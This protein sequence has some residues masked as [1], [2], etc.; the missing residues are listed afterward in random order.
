M[1]GWNSLS[2]WRRYCYGD[3]EPRSV[4]LA[5]PRYLPFPSAIPQV[6]GEPIL[7]SVTVLP[8]GGTASVEIIPASVLSRNG[9]Q[10][11]TGVVVTTQNPV[12]SGATVEA[13]VAERYTLINGEVI[14]TEPFF[15]DITLYSWPDDG[16]NNT[17]SAHFPATP[18]KIYPLGSLSY[19]EVNVEVYLKSSEEGPV[20]NVIG[21]NGGTLIGNDGTGIVVPPSSLT[22]VTV[23]RLY[24]LS[25]AEL[26]INKPGNLSFIGAMI[27]QMQG[28]SFKPGAFPQF[29]IPGLSASE[30]TKV[31][32]TRV[33]NINGENQLTAVAIATVSG[34]RL[35]VERCLSISA[36]QC[37][38]SGSYAFYIPG[39]PFG[40][41]SGNVV[42]GAVPAPGVIISVNNLPFKGLS[43]ASGG[44]LVL[45]LSGD[46]TVKALEAGT[47]QTASASGTIADGETRTVTLSLTPA[48]RVTAVDPRDKAT[49]VDLKARIKVTF[50]APVNPATV[51]ST[52][53]AVI[54][55]PQVIPPDPAP[56]QGYLSFTAQNTVAV[57]TPNADLK[58]DY[59]YRVKLTSEIKD[60]FGNS[61]VPF[62]SVFTTASVLPNG[63]LPPGALKVSMPDAEGFVI[64][65]GG[66]GLSAPGMP[67]VIINKTQNI[68]LTVIA[69]DDGSFEGKIKAS[70]T[71]ELVV[72]V[73]DLLGNTTTMSPGLFMNDDGTAAVGPKGGT[74][75][76]PGDIRAIVRE[77]AF[78]N[79]IPVKVTMVS[80]ESIKDVSI[81][82]EIRTIG[83]FDIDSGGVESQKEF[84]VS[85][86]APDWVT[87]EHQIL[88][89]EVVNVRGFDE[90]TLA[91]PA[92]LKDGRIESTTPP[93]N[94]VSST[95]RY[96]VTTWD[97]S[98]KGTGY[99]QV[100]VWSPYESVFIGG[101][102][103]FVFPT[104]PTYKVVGFP[105]TV[106]TS[107]PFIVD[108]STINGTIMDSVSI[109]GPPQRGQFFGITIR[110]V[111][112]NVPPEVVRTSIAQD[113]TDIPLE[114]NIV[115]EMNE[116]I[117]PSTVNISTVKVTDSSGNG[118]EGR[119]YLAADEK[120]IVFVPTFGYHLATEYTLQ[121]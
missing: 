85:I 121:S 76:G 119:V 23:F 88:I 82:P 68:V 50:S 59:F 28:G 98:S 8:D 120:T 29:I 47:G 18:S 30:G 4:S 11:M 1:G 7:P 103:G 75:Y 37:I 25:E 77:G 13:K 62:E 87:P 16:K 104:Q 100:E 70:I 15:Q 102:F 53:F 31:I 6:A 99:A 115:I 26:P 55:T 44:F 5:R 72:E 57:F 79:T 84:K 91:C 93:F 117:D 109:L 49:G 114:E 3:T 95:G 2:L 81:D 54:E 52:S 111:N 74:I 20:E 14:T 39:R 92:F 101:D 113:A 106:P 78:E 41:I 46:Y 51:S 71:D 17:L 34:G 10:G 65:R 32:V 107:Q 60:T 48:V 58:P 56:I 112:D 61:L 12:P 9:V 36:T 110:L 38:S 24:P 86:P 69:N 64:V 118:V 90:L 108:L 19:G 42:K 97:D 43:D 40:F 94:G 96:V 67:V 105:I 116:P 63:S 83:V 27:L 45:S 89:T 33:Q 35:A 80:E 73:K 21:E 22:A 66:P